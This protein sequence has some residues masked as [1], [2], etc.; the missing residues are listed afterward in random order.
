MT[1]SISTAS[2]ASAPCR[3]AAATSVPL[4]APRINT[5]VEGVAEHRVRPLVEVFLLRHRR[6]RLVKDV[7]HLDDGVGLVLEDRDAVV[8]RPQA[9]A[10]PCDGRSRAMPTSSTTLDGWRSHPPAARTRDPGPMTAARP[11]R[12]RRTRR[13]AAARATTPSQMRATP[14]R[15]PSRLI[16]YARSG[17]SPDRSRPI[18]CATRRTAPRPM[19]N[20]S[21]SS[22]CS[23]P[24]PPA[25]SCRWRSRSSRCPATPLRAAAD[26]PPT[27]TASWISGNHTNRF[28]PRVASRHPTPMPRKLARRMKFEK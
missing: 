7:V 8:R 14:A 4:P 20:S 28:A 18:R 19:T 23:R 5:L 9:A 22:T 3:S 10:L 24:A 25:P 1:G 11:R 26:R 13:S 21:G 6:H 16:T 17:G 27:I 2:R 15:L 12:Q